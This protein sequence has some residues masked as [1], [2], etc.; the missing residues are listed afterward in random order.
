MVNQS[1]RSH[2]SLQTLQQ[3]V[4]DVANAHSVEDQ[5]QRL[6]TL[7]RDALSVG[8]CSLYQQTDDQTLRLVANIGFRKNAVGS[9][10]LPIGAG[11]VGKIASERLL[12]N[13]AVAPDHPAFVHFPQSGE[14][15]FPSFLGAPIVYLGKVIGVL[16]VQDTKPVAFSDDE[17]SFLITIAAQL[18]SVLLK[19]AADEQQTRAGARTPSTVRGL[20][21]APG[22]TIGAVHLVMSERTL[23][24]VDE[25]TAR[26]VDEELVV[27]SHAVSKAA[28]DID[29][30]KSRLGVNVGEDVLDLF[31]FY[32]AMLSSDQL[33]AA[34]E[35]RVHAG[36]SAFAAVRIIV[37]EHVRAFEAIEDEYLRAR[38]EDIRHIGNKLLLA[39]LGQISQPQTN[40][41]RI[42]LLGDTVGIA[43]IGAFAPDQLAGV[44]CFGSSVLSHTALLARSLGIPAVVATGPIGHISDG[45]QI[46]VDG[47][48]GTVIFEPSAIVLRAYRSNIVRDQKFQNELL[49]QVHMPAITS[50]G[51]KVQLL[52]NSALLGDVS[53][54][55]MHGAEGI[56]LYRSE[57]QF[58]T[59][60]ALPTEAE[61]YTTYRA[62]LEAYHPLPV[63]M[64]SLDVGGDK[65]LPYLPI[66]EDNPAL[67]WRG[68]RFALDNPAILV[69]QLRAMLRANFELGNL[70]I[71][72]PMV[73]SVN[74]V[75]EVRRMLDTIVA[76]LSGQ[77]IDA[78]VPPLGIMV[79]IP[80][81][82]TLLPY[83]APYIEFVSVGSNDL[84][85]YLLAV[86]RGNPRV[87]SHY[88]H[89]HPCVLR[90]LA[91]IIRSAKKLQL[92]ASVCGEMASD[93][94]AV[95]ILL[96]LGFNSLSLNAF[97][98][99]RIR[100]L[101]RSIS[102][103]QAARL[104]KRALKA[105]D[106]ALIREL[107]RNALVKQGWAH[108]LDPGH[109]QMLVETN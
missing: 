83:L 90:T 27:L 34:A 82:V 107:L 100:V 23:R 98:L 66:L 104:A 85:Q 26:S 29:A 60:N 57:I 48:A 64:R 68:I 101:I 76:E 2:V 19:L 6:V 78:V 44:V 74:E 92:Q 79:E 88:D 13:L 30:A 41:R 45:Q 31:E 40:V 59:A 42:V 10:T 8:A 99:A 39:I 69:T 58:L 24:L 52:A 22:K 67:G 106:A 71:M 14:K 35:K 81:T 91:S 25:P 3:I 33:V 109:E 61:Q 56:G 84:T 65:Q 55:K 94:L 86:D 53:P 51:F 54:A 96:G 75:R 12:L 46:I 63:T 87:A 103:Q 102:Q 21:A 5:V 17:Q 47:D 93:P 105:H 72:F 80:A 36:I 7:V 73:G 18:G 15:A 16:V 37:D 11:L 50:D 108:L 38:S 77:G 89:L 95:V 97:G 49:A 43:D 70:R 1:P 4:I 62:L 28:D 20:S 32:K 9:I